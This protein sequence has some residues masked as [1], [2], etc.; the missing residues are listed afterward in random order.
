MVPHHPASIHIVHLTNANDLMSPGAQ[1]D[2]YHWESQ[3]K[4][5]STALYGRVLI[6]KYGAPNPKPKALALPRRQAITILTS[7]VSLGFR[8]SKVRFLRVSEL[9]FRLREVFFF[10]RALFRPREVSASGIPFRGEQVSRP[11]SSCSQKTQPPAFSLPTSYSCVSLGALTDRTSLW[12]S[13]PF[14]PHLLNL[15]H[16]LL[17]WLREV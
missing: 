9:G 5:C 11:L 1:R 8:Y 4:L 17:L 16:S 13:P 6:R 15:F 3:I 7:S 12:F 14:F 2:V 10:L